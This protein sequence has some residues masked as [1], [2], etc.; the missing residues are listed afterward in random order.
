[1]PDTTPL[2][3]QHARAPGSRFSDIDLSESLFDDVNLQRATFENTTLAGARFRDVSLKDVSVEDAGLEG[4]TINGILVSELL[5]AYEAS[6]APREPA[7]AVLFA[8]DPY[9][10]AA[11]YTGVAGLAACHAAPDHLVLASPAVQLTLVAIPEAIAAGIVIASPP[12]RREETPIKLVFSVASLAEAR[13]AAA[14]L[15]GVIDPPGREWP[16]RG[17]RVCD[18]HDPEG[19]V[20]Q[21][22]ERIG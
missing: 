9:L 18:G 16:Y 15:G 10:L 14:D 5:L 7:A 12:V 3:H 1:M 13:N 20:L 2:L 19:N 17:W 6:Q 4:M 22:R 21:L 8:K 11:F